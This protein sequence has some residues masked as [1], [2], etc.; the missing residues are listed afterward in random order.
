MVKQ[1]AVLGSTGSIGC[2]TLQVVRHLKPRFRVAA[3][4]AKS[5]VDL[6]VQQARE[7]QPD[8]VVIFDKDKAP[9]L[10]KHL[11]GYHIAAGI[12]GLIEAASYPSVQQVVCAISGT[13]GLLPTLAAIEAEKQIALANKEA[14]VS[15]GELVMRQALA[16]NV[17]ILPVDSEH[18]ALFQALNGA[19]PSVVNRLILTASGGPFRTLPD[20]K[21]EMI[22]PKDALSHPTWNM[23][24][25]ITIDCSTLMNKGLEVIEAHWLFNMPLDKIEVVVHPQSVIHSMVEYID[26]SMIAQM[27]A[28]S[29]LIPIQYAL[30]Y[31]ER[32]QGTMPSF[33][34]FR[35]PALEFSAP[36]L[37]RFICLRLAVEALRI[38]GSLPCF[39]NAAN[40]VLVARFLDHQ[41]SWIEIGRKLEKLMENHSVQQILTVDS[42]VA[43]DS[44][45]REEA[46][47]V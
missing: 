15:G 4:A 1:I 13:I 28:P 16:K 39:M 7:F 19:S 23:G 32:C 41:I 2:S 44:L 37:Q 25:K 10:Q 33:S 17:Q 24:K 11:P 30:T 18:S 47:C 21:L 12:E 31:P 40:E 34:F 9:E 26:G 43:V 46:A 36:D 22:T 6:L 3:L 29:M 20:E 8:I 35:Y 27:S 5:N 42:I 45:A 14:L 38:G